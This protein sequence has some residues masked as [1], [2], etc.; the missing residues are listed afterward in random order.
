MRRA[1]SIIPL[2]LVSLSFA[3]E[4]APKLDTGDTAWLL[5][6]SALVMLMTLPGLALFYG[7]MA[8]KKDTLNTIAMSFVAYCIASLVWFAY[9][10]SLAFGE[11]IGGII[12]SASK[13]FLSGVGVSSLQGTIPELLFVMFQLTFA[14]ITVAL[15]SG[16]F[17]ERL[18]FS[19]WVVFVFLWVSLVYVPIAH[20]VWGGGFLA[21]DGA[22]DFAGGTVVHINAGIAGLVGALILGRRKDAVLLPS[23]LPL[24]V[25]GAGLLWFG[26]FGF[27]AGSAVGANGLAAVAMLNTNIATATAALAWMF[28]EWLHRKKP[29][30]L[31]LAS[32]VIAGLVAITPAAGF[33]NVVGAFIIGLIAG[34]VCYFMVAEVKQKLGYDDALDVFGIHGVAGIIG[35]VLTGVFADPSINEAGKGLLYGNPGQLF[36]QLWSV[37]VTIVY[38]GVMTAI[39]LFIARALTGLKVGEEEEV[40]GLDRSQHGESAYNIS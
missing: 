34:I 8:K 27:N 6:S 23:N 12:G 10:Y 2:L 9:G 19:A 25:L 1:G 35:A 15:A 16:S 29:T 33:V 20:W 14:A 11:D 30:V 36:I 37:V 13:L 40:G 24:V 4:Q 22:L 26:W 31:G 18:K 7:G 38:S 39:I 17:V 28:T 32:G 5:V 3:G 21:K